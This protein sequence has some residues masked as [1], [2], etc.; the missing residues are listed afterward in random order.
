M[1]SDISD[2]KIHLLLSIEVDSLLRSV[3]DNF[4]K[5]RVAEKK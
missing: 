2:I 4:D 1:I 5:Y 3:V